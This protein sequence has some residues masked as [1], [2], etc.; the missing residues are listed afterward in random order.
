MTIISMSRQTGSLGDEMAK[1]VADQLGFEHIGKSQI[2][3]TLS[4]HGFP[5]SDVDKYDEK[6]PSIWQTL[7]T[8]NKIFA[9]LIQA[10]IY[11]LAAKENVVI[12][13]RGAQAILKDIP[14]TLHVRVI[15]PYITRVH[16]L[17][18]QMGY[19]EEQA[20]QIIRQSD[21]NSSGYIKTYFDINWDDSDLY[22]LVINTRITTLK[23]GVEMITRAVGTDEFKKNP[24]AP[25]KLRDLSLTQKV[26][27]ALLEVGGPE[28]VNLVV[29]K[30]VVSLSGFVRSHATKEKCE[31]A[32]LNIKGVKELNGQLDLTSGNLRIY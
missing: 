20:H 9:H 15:A 22:D 3:A 23:T 6:K 27:A 11:E 8:Q 28:V 19:E 30:G 4:N 18:E 2:S 25:E 17:M 31:K 1:A 29:Q 10:A 24:P 14:G 16:R 7:F 32:I 5:E 21:R 13:G 12:V 26:R